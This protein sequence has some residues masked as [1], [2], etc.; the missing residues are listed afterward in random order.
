MQLLRVFASE[1][2][3]QRRLRACAGCAHSKP[4]ARMHAT[5]QLIL[6]YDY[7]KPARLFGANLKETSVC[8]CRASAYPR[9]TLIGGAAAT[10]SNNLRMSH[11]F[12]PLQAL[13]VALR[14][15]AP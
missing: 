9:L 10:A 12:P 3:K 5:I 13:H 4:R 11:C 1:T 14:R 2:F 6:M 8:R 15:Q 7:S